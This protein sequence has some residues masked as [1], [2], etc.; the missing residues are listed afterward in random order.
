MRDGGSVM[1]RAHIRHI[2]VVVAISA[3]LVPHWL[4]GAGAAGHEPLS[5]VVALGAAVALTL[6]WGL[7]ENRR[8]PEQ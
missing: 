3:V 4:P 6:V 1:M 5:F 2:C 7:R 8:H